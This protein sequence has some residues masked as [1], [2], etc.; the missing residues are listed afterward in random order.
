[1]VKPQTPST[2]QQANLSVSSL[3]PKS[4]ELLSTPKSNDTTKLQT[5]S[6]NSWKDIEKQKQDELKEREDRKKK[7]IGNPKEIAFS[8]TSRGRK[9][10]K[11]RFTTTKEGK[12]AER[13]RREKKE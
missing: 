4:V 7:M 1:V 8:H 3:T 9:G 5:S 2:P 13:K 12:G 11:S 6:R 10:E